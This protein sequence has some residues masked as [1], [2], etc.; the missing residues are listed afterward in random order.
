MEETAV[1]PL[2]GKSGIWHEELENSHGRT[3]APQKRRQCPKFVKNSNIAVQFAAKSRTTPAAAV[4]TVPALVVPN[5]M[6]LVEGLRVVC[7]RLT[8]Y[9]G[10]I[11]Q[12]H[13]V[14]LLNSSAVLSRYRAPMETPRRAEEGKLQIKSSSQYASC[15]TRRSG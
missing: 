1:G 2:Q 14:R 5:I 10:C 8:V 7:E 12:H 9:P 6:A 3:D 15:N 13:A 4:G 11:A